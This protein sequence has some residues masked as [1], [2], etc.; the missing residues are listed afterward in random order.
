M[1]AHDPWMLQAGHGLGLAL[2]ALHGAHVRGAQLQDL[3]GH[4]PLDANVACQVDG[5]HTAPAQLP[6][7]LVM[8]DPGSM[9]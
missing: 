7:D 4:L 6:Q 8:T 2:K 5:S 1:D 3:D 9:C